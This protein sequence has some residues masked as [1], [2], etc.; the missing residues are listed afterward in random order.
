MKYFGLKNKELHFA[1]II[2]H[3]THSGNMML[4]LYTPDATATIGLGSFDTA[5]ISYDDFVGQYEELE[6]ISLAKQIYS[7]AGIWF[8]PATIYS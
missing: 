1:V 8:N 2:H 6:D 3:N 4:K 5:I 7:S